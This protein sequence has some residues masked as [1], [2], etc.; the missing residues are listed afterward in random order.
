MSRLLP[1]CMD[2]ES[3]RKG[4]KSMYLEWFLEWLSAALPLWNCDSSCD[5]DFYNKIWHSYTFAVNVLFGNQNN[6][7]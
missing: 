1:H 3:C 7:Y 2:T 5:I 6:F 4:L